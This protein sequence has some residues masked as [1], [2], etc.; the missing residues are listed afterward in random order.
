MFLMFPSLSSP[1]VLFQQAFTDIEHTGHPGRRDDILPAVLLD[2]FGEVASDDIA[3]P[4]P[5][6]QLLRL[7]QAPPRQDSPGK[8]V[9]LLPARLTRKEISAT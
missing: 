2:M 6:Q 9:F 8:G 7:L 3:G 1:P 4:D 5:L